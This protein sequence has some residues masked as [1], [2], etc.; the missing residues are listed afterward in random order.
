M[1]MLALCVVSAEAV[2]YY[3]RSGSTDLSIVASCT[4]D[5]DGTQ[6][7][8]SL[9]GSADVS[10]DA[11]NKAMVVAHLREKCVCDTGGREIGMRKG[12]NISE[13]F[14]YDAADATECVQKA[15]DSGEPCIV[16]DKPLW[17]VRPLHVTRSNFELVIPRGVTLKAK[18]GEYHV[19]EDRLLLIEKGASNVVVRGGGTLSMWKCD[20]I[21]PLKY[22]WSE[23]RH[24]LALHEV[25]N[26][27]IQDIA[28][29]SSGGDGIYIRDSKDIQIY[30]VRS[31]D[32]N[33]QGMSVIGAENL[34]V[35]GCIFETTGGTAPQCGL[36]IEPNHSRNPLKNIVFDDCLFS[37]NRMCGALV[38]LAQ[39]TS[40]SAPV[41]ISFRNCRSTGNGDCGYRVYGGGAKG[42]PKGVVS[43]ENCASSGNGSMDLYY[44][45]RI[46]GGVEAVTRGCSF[47][48]IRQN[49]YEP[50]EDAA[51]LDLMAL[52][53]PIL[54]NPARI[55]SSGRCRSDSNFVQWTPKAGRYKVVFVCE[56]IGTHSFS[57]ELT[58]RDRLGTH[59]GTVKLDRGVN[60]YVIEARGENLYCFEAVVKSGTI[61][62]RSAFAGAG[63]CAD[64]GVSLFASPN[65]KYF[66][67]APKGPEP[68]KVYLRPE[69]PYSARLISPEGEIVDSYEYGTDTKM[70][71]SKPRSLD[72]DASVWHLELTKVDEDLFFRIVSPCIPVAWL[73]E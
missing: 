56:D 24:A 63:V 52:R 16:L 9:P 20:Y 4:M 57:G 14:G 36:D 71:R 30:N 39:Q 41:S 25:K 32:H 46:K 72:E 64:R 59:L 19:K 18:R 2:P 1:M 55:L 33:R 44:D 6:A 27:R 17:Y 34:L 10:A 29:E 47:K 3:L 26:V 43:F 62:F 58:V 40:N 15:L 61:E 11:F 50:P 38:H 42:N 35:R 68:V 22:Q 13:R 21:D 28:I 7:A 48:R 8:T 31:S 23:W 54:T 53:P 73:S 66:I 60:E 51:P 67:V 37:S 12:V 5:A 49:T 65:R 70:L 45:H 69:E